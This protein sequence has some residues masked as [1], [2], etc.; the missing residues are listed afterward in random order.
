M[1]ERTNSL[2]A[3]NAASSYRSLCGPLRSIWFCSGGGRFIEKCQT[4]AIQS[5]I[6][7]I[8]AF[9]SSV[10]RYDG[11]WCLMFDEL[12]IAP[13]QIQEVLFRSLRA[14]DQRLIFKLA[15]SPSTQ[16]ASVFRDALGPSEGNDFEE[17]S[18]YSDPKESAIFCENLWQNWRWGRMQAIFS[19]MRYSD[20][21]LFYGPESSSPYSKTGHWQKASTSLALKDPSYRSFMSHYG[22]DP[23]ALALA[24]PHQRDAVVRKIGPIVGFRD[25]MLKWDPKRGA[26]S[27][28]HDK[29]KPAQ[30]FSGWE[31]LCT[32]SI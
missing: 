28:R 32:V 11:R 9:D 27:V 14:S 22:I 2:V 23:N 15:L 5:A 20:T 12:E 21:R 31:V 10:N 13:A 4:Q 17:I 3:W 26:T 1:S 18:L 29:T 25:F 19:R 24:N 30:L 6:R 7:G 16:A 8:T